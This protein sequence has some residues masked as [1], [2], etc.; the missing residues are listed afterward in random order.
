MFDMLVLLCIYFIRRP[1]KLRAYLEELAIARGDLQPGERRVGGRRRE[2]EVRVIVLEHAL[3]HSPVL[4]LYN[5]AKECL[6]NL[7]HNLTTRMLN[8]MKVLEEAGNKGVLQTRSLENVK[9]TRGANK[10]KDAPKTTG[11]TVPDRVFG[12]AVTSN[13]GA[14]SHSNI[15]AFLKKKS[16][17]YDAKYRHKC[18]MTT[19]GLRCASISGLKVHWNIRHAGVAFPVDALP[20]A[21]APAPAAAAA[22][23]AAA[24]PAAA[25]ADA[26]AAAPPNDASLAAPANKRAKLLHSE[27]DYET[28]PLDNRRYLKTNRS[29][30]LTSDVHTRALSSAASSQ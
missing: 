25:A 30:H 21:A 11:I 19:C 28:C 1:A 17:D 12:E 15:A 5:E 2:D 22:A 6:L 29:A 26:A 27:D 9:K 20:P 8:C 13:V 10:P 4:Q 18:P 23:A 16:A 14:Q 7:R 24:L 3:S